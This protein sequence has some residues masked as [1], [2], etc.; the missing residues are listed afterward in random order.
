MEKIISKNTKFFVLF[1]EQKLAE[2]SK[3]VNLPHIHP[4]QVL[5]EKYFNGNTNHYHNNKSLKC[6]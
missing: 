2:N 5:E 3:N 4:A 6:P 1:F